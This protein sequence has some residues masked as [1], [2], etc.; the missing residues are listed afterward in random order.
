M[1]GPQVEAIADRSWPGM[2]MLEI[3]TEYGKLNGR[4]FVKEKPTERFVAS[5]YKAHLE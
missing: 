1:E 3:N 2:R 5:L 4:N